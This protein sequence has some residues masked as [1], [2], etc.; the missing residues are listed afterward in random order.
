[1]SNFSIFLHSFSVPPLKKTKSGCVPCTPA[2]LASCVTGKGKKRSSTTK[3]DNKR[4]NCDK[5]EV[6]GD[7][8]EETDDVEFPELTATSFCEYVTSTSLD[9][10]TSPNAQVV[11]EELTM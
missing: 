8:A 9:V 3:C 2:K 1:M 11:Q 7:T 4:E 6:E 10:K 5:E